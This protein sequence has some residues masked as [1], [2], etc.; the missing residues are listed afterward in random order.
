ML[1]CWMGT[2]SLS[3]IFENLKDAKGFL[4]HLWFISGSVL[5]KSTG[6][7][8]S[9][10]QSKSC[11]SV[12]VLCRSILLQVSSVFSITPWCKKKKKSTN[13]GTEVQRLL[14]LED[15][16]ALAL[17]TFQLWSLKQRKQVTVPFLHWVFA[18]VCL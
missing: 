3:E 8:C 1:F 6:A 12:T 7:L 13:Y 5:L 10:S 17:Q 16:C 9:S 4:Y 2:L 11:P 14:T 15:S 18:Y